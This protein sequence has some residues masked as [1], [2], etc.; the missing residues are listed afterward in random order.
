MKITY[1]H[2]R[3]DKDQFFHLYE[4]TGWNERYQLTA[5]EVYHALDATWHS[6]SAYD[7]ERLVGFG[8]VI[9][10]GILH[11]LI[12]E[13]IILPEYQGQGIGRVIMID[14]IAKCKQHE[15]RD[16]Q[17]FC[18]RGKVGFYEKFGFEKRPD[19]A[20]G[21]GIKYIPNMRTS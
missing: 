18:A 11:A 7:G 12:T 14:L 9:G 19:E 5:D 20:P 21:M 2:T 3:P 4:S 16:I 17:L 13:M 8:R 1:N 6:I 15:I 10:D